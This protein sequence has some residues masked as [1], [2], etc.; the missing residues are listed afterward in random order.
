MLKVSPSCKINVSNRLSGGKSPKRN[1][2]PATRTSSSQDLFML[3]DEEGDPLPSAKS[4]KT[5]PYRVYYAKKP[6]LA[7]VKAYYAQIRSLKPEQQMMDSSDVNSIEA[8]AK[9]VVSDGDLIDKYMHK[10][11]SAMTEPSSYIRLRRPDENKVR[12]YFVGYE[13]VM[14]PNKHEIEK[15][16]IKVAVAKIR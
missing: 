3:V 1:R 10:V 15:G 4:E 6:S 14:K 2:D 11:R 7:A 8:E 13:R 12:T 16:I 5:I 9:K